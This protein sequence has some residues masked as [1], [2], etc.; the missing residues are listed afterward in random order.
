MTYLY[1]N[2]KD[3]TFQRNPAR[4]FEISNTSRYSMGNDLGIEYG[5]DTEIF[6]LRTMLAEES[7]DLDEICGE[8]K[9]E[10]YVI[11]FKKQFGYNDQIRP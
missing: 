10:V 1:L 2:Q 4:L 7:W 3:G 9:P 5:D 8:D 11:K 6:I